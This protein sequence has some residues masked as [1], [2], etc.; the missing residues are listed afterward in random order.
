MF[1]VE[2]D[3]NE[4]EQESP[5]VTGLAV[6]VRNA[7]H[8]DCGPEARPIHS[9]LA[10]GSHRCD[11]PTNLVELTRNEAPGVTR[12]AGGSSPSGRAGLGDELRAIRGNLAR[13]SGGQAHA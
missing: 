3:G 2:F 8:P 4:G 11:Y 9:L 5:R 6:R 12:S 10:N 1:G 7:F 13:A